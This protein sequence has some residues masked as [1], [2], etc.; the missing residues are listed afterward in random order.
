MKRKDEKSIHFK[1]K[2]NLYFFIEN[3]HKSF[4]KLSKNTISIIRKVLL[5]SSKDADILR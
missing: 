1:L 4:S 5:C 3:E 2:T